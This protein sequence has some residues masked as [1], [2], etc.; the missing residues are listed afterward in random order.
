MKNQ[1]ELVRHKTASFLSTEK[2]PLHPYLPL[3]N[4]KEARCAQEV[5]TK[6]IIQYALAGLHNGALANELVAWLKEIYIWESLNSS[7]KKLLKQ[8]E[9]SEKEKNVVSWKQ[10]S[11]LMLGWALGLV[12]PPSIHGEC[13]LGP[14][15]NKIPPEVEAKH[16]L[17]EMTL[18]SP[19]RIVE[20]LDIYYCLHAALEH[21]E[22]WS[23][24]IPKSLKIQCVTE[25]RRSLE[26]ILDSSTSWDDIS[27]DT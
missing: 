25:R 27:L 13:I 23:I 26:W 10:E 22:L 8:S 17:N 21:P 6:L 4:E 20:M 12:E 1:L 24:E 9:L 11:L 19:I 16:F 15:F 14:L 18:V 2:V 7:E 3:R 5:G